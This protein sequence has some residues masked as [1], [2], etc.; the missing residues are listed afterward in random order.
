MSNRIEKIP[1]LDSLRGIS[2]LLVVYHHFAHEYQLPS[3]KYL[4]YA[5]VSIFFVISGFLITSILLKQKEAVDDRILIIKNFIIKRALRLFPAY[6]LVLIFFLVLLVVFNFR[7]WDSGNGIYYF[8]YTQN[9]LFFVKGVQGIQ[10]N[11]LWS[12]AVEEQFY[13][14]WPWAVIFVLRKKVI[15]ALCIIIPA[16]VISKI[17]FP[18]QDLWMFPFYHFDTLGSGALIAY[19]GVKVPDFPLRSALNF[20]ILQK[21][22]V[23]SYGIYLYHKPVPTFLD[24]IFY[25]THVQAPGIVMLLLSFVITILLSYV[26]Y[27]VLEKPFLKLK[28][29]FDL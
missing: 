12:L 9:I 13:L 17:I 16:T 14:L 6:Y 26:S 23:I 2:V 3:L 28:D 24:I 15:S 25:K 5:G 20:S 19:L 4:G 29:R 11:H 21:L 22:G 8:T 1:Q 7:V 18:M 27:R 10:L